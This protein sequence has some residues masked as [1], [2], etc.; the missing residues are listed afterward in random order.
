[1][2][3]KEFKSKLTC[4]FLAGSFLLTSCAPVSGPDKTFVG[5]ILGAGWGAGAGAIIGN[6]VTSP[7]GPGIA[8][9]AGMGLASGLIAGAGHDVAEGYQ[10]KAERRLASLEGMSSYNQAQINRVQSDINK[11]IAAKENEN[12]T[13]FVEV[14]FDEQR[15]SLLRANVL[16]LEKLA[17]HVRNKRI[18]SYSVKLKGFSTDFQT[19]A[20]NRELIEARVKTVETLLLSFGIPQQYIKKDEVDGTSLKLDGVK[21]LQQVGDLVTSVE[22]DGSRLNNRVEV[23]VDFSS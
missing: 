5:G 7:I 14:F 12:D 22:G 10:L 13:P 3:F 9:G 23:Y 6:Q 21:N 19:K 18:G 4:S 16:R 17:S 1:M 20:T 15:A 2:K 11:H 8:I